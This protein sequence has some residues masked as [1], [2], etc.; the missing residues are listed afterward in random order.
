MAKH[1]IP[2]ANKENVTCK[3]PY[4]MFC[5]DEDEESREAIAMEEPNDVPSMA[6]M[7]TLIDVKESMMKKMNEMTKS[8]EENNKRTKKMVEEM[9]DQMK[10]MNKKMDKM[11]LKDEA[12]GMINKAQQDFV[13]EAKRELRD[14]RKPLEDRTENKDMKS[15]NNVT[16]KR[17]EGAIVIRPN[18]QQ[19]SEVTKKVIKEKVD[20]KSMH[21]GISRFRKGNNGKHFILFSLSLSLSSSL[22]LSSLIACKDIATMTDVNQ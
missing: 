7:R 18:K 1:R 13:K 17:K 5:A 3:G 22:P 15:Y 19:E 14:A 21:V 16:K 8:I 4:D 2:N 9:R 12:E 20:I 10:E 11:I 6:M